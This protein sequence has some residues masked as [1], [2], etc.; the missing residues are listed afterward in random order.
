MEEEQNYISVPRMDISV[1]WMKNLLE[2]AKKADRD[3]KEW[4][5]NC[6]SLDPLSVSSLVGWSLSA[7]EIIKCRSIKSIPWKYRR[8]W[9]DNKLK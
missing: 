6:E 1:Q 3:L 4:R 5:V 8:G 2:A 9:K 7:E